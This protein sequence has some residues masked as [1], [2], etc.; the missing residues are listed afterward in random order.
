MTFFLRTAGRSRARP[1]ASS[2]LTRLVLEELESRLVPTYGLSGNAWPAPQLVTISFVPDGTLMT[3]GVGGKR[4]SL[5]RLSVTVDS[6]LICGFAFSRR[7]P[8]NRRCWNTARMPD[9][10]GISRWNS[11]DIGG[12]AGRAR[13]AIPSSPAS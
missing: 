9:L 5:L 12:R 10:S 8:K 11:I 2:P 1:S 13:P 4:R 6:V 7:P 3:S